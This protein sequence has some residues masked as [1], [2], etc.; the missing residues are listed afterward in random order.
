MVLRLSVGLYL[1]TTGLLG[2]REWY[3][4]L[5]C[6]LAGSIAVPVGHG[7]RA[8]GEMSWEA[9]RLRTRG[10]LVEGHRVYARTYEFNDVE[11]RTRR[12]TDDYASGERVE[13]LH[14]PAPGRDTA[15]IGR[16]TTGTL[17]FAGCVCL[18]S[19]VMA[20][21]LVAIGLAGPLAALGV[22]SLGL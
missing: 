19:L 15:R 20:A 1:L 5:G 12:L 10:A 2:T 3:V 13:I 21:A 17:V 18:L 6:W 8:G 7:V 4:A 9:W 14:D 16:R 11:G 22:I